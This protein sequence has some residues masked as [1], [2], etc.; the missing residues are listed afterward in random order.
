MRGRKQFVR[1]G[2]AMCAACA[3]T[4]SSLPAVF[5]YADETNAPEKKLVLHY[6][7][8]SLKSGTIVNDISGNGMAGGR[9]DRK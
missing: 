8:D 7:F 1:K 5:V 3:M 6:D 9:P 4:V 2:I